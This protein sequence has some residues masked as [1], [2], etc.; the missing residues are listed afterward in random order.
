MRTP[1]EIFVYEGD[2]GVAFAGEEHAIVLVV[3]V[4]RASTTL[5]VLAEKGA[6]RIYVA[7]EVAEAREAAKLLGRCVLA[8]ERKG[9][10]ACSEA[11]SKAG[12]PLAWSSLE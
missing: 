11:S 12:K 9:L 10:P 6:R 4:L 3:D 7:A 2:S 8:G 5:V 1:P